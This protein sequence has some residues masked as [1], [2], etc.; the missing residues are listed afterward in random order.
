MHSIGIDF[1]LPVHL[2]RKQYHGPRRALLA[3]T[4]FLPILVGTTHAEKPELDPILTID[5]IYDSDDFDGERFG[6]ARWLDHRT[7]Y[8]TLD[9]ATGPSG[10][11]DIV[12]HDPVTG[13]A[14]VLVPSRLLVPAGASSS[15]S[16]D[17]YTWSED[18]S[19]LLIFTNTKKVW[20][21][22]TRG[23]YWVLDVAA[24]TLHQV[25]GDADP[26][27]LMFAKFSPD[28]Q[29]VGYVHKNNV[30]AEELHGGK[31]TQL[32]TDGSDI[33]INGNFDWVYEEELSLQDGFRWSPDSS[34]IAYWQIDT[35][36]VRSF[37]LLNNTAGLYPELKTFAYPKVGETN[38]AGRVGVVSASGGKTRWMAIPG[39]PRNHYIARM[40]WADNSDELIVQQFNRLQNTNLVMLADAKTDLA[41][42][43][44][45][46]RDDAWVDQHT[47]LRWLDDGEK[48]T[49]LSERD[50]WQHLYTASRDGGKA[51]LVTRGD[52]DVV[53]I[54][55][56]DEDNGWVYY[57]ASPDNPLQRYLYRVRLNG[58]DTQR[59]TPT[60]QRGTHRYQVSPDGAWAIHTYSKAGTPP[61]KD[62]VKLPEH[63]SVR[64]L[65]EN[66]E[67][68]KAVEALARQ[69]IEFF[70]IDI[71]N[72]IE[73]DAYCIKPPDFDPTKKYPVLFHVYGE[74]WG[75]TVA[76]GWGGNG[77]LWHLML[78][79]KGYLVM[80]IDN[81][82]TRS[83]RGR[84]WRK[85]VYR[86]IG[87]LASQEQAAAARAILAER[88]YVDAERIGIWGWSG[89]GS[90][91]L[92]MV[93]RHPELYSMGMSVAPVPNQRYY[94]TIYQERYMGLPGDNAEGYR[95]GSPITHAGG[96]E[97]KL[98]LVHGT[99]DDNVHFQGTEALINELIALNKPFTMMAYPN[100]SHGIGEGANTTRHVYN[101]LT[102]YL[103]ENLP[104]G[105]RDR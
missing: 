77:Y 83:P 42:T 22:N 15:L 30:Y 87:I 6:P 32:T 54:A 37:H 59:I 103:K 21:G 23:D 16:I 102:R 56:L 64:M 28:G 13:D 99:G 51:R 61:V 100:R 79:Q 95:E 25:G 39:D 35:E 50:G 101:L 10:G 91:T 33:V 68:R 65:T 3:I 4:F 34:A 67:Q 41:E 92:N 7:G 52:F 27:T 19:L 105:P 96:L 43:I 104:S 36:G 60:D 14:E 45:T 90:M 44:L 97:G 70:R 40:D 98:L 24:R 63:E 57:I 47:A 26:S 62:L 76:D 17:N 74:P 81:Q 85:I 8:T 1:R 46:E 53:D 9:D 73:L 93:F 88:P 58:R 38:S 80:S 94:D 55:G 12:L 78:A 89:G 31:I 71:G 2:I 49:W 11:R 29:R 82:G 69:P 84:D 75:Q 20:R 66:E 86:Q 72:G 48:F 5:R 18:G